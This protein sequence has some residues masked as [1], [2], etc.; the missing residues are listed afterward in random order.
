ML[1]VLSVI[2]YAIVV[3]IAVLLIALIL[4]QPSKSG[5]LG[6][7]FGGVGESVFG[8]HAMS[9]LSKLTVI[10]IT[11]FFIL[12]LV[13]AVISG[14]NRENSGT[15][16]MDGVTAETESRAAVSLPEPANASYAEAGAADLQEQVKTAAE[17]NGAGLPP[18][19]SAA[20]VPSEK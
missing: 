18:E 3:L 10:F 15:S 8:A 5:G 12:T 19:A 16:V 2:L 9:H 11:I 7:A 17:A 13:L 6:S 4:L 20:S 14:H 1:S